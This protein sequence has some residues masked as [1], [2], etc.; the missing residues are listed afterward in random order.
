MCRW[1]ITPWQQQGGPDLAVGV[2][3]EVVGVKVGLGVVGVK[4]GWGWWW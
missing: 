2:G 1:L 3:L 4:V